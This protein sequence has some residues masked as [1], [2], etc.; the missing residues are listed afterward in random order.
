MLFNSYV[1][2]F[3]FLPIALLGYFICN[4]FGKYQLANIFL[5]GMSLWFYGYF[6][7]TYLPIICGSIL[8]NYFFQECSAIQQLKENIVQF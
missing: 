4:K 1:F 8:I 7:I 6:N 3:A 5:I 2:I